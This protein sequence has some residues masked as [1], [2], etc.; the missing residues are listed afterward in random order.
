ML[1]EL[2][3]LL[4]PEGRGGS[5][6]NGRGREFPGKGESMLRIIHQ[7]VKVVHQGNI[8]YF[9]MAGTYVCGWWEKGNR[10]NHYENG[11]VARDKAGRKTSRPR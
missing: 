5:G 11:K 3:A 4:R 7:R 6:K 2:S 8:K 9:S 10:E 1:V